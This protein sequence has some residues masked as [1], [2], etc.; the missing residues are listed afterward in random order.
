MVIA[1]TGTRVVERIRVGIPGIVAGQQVVGAP[2]VTFTYKGT[3][4]AR[5][6]FARMID[7]SARVALGAVA[8]PVPLVLDGKR[9]TVSIALG[10]IVYSAG[11][12]PGLILQ[13]SSSD[14]SFIQRTSGQVRITGITVD[15]PV[16]A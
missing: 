8:T 16:V 4:S 3:G 13:L 9:H 5:A 2:T 11:A 12:N 6:M 7:T 10:D 14:A 15:V 1:P